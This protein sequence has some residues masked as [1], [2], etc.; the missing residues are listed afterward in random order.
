M[1]VSALQRNRFLSNWSR[2][3]AYRGLSP[4]WRAIRF[5]TRR[6]QR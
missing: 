2:K 3:T 1:K 5:A 6:R 4:G